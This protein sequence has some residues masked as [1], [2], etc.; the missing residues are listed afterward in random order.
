MLEMTLYLILTKR[1]VRLLTI[2]EA[3]SEK[4]YTYQP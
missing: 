1:A 3:Q 2:H 4:H